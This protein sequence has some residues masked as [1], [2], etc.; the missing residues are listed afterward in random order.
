MFIKTQTFFKL[1]PMVRLGNRT[2]RGCENRTYRGC[3]NRTY[4]G[5]ESRIQEL[6]NSHL[7]H[8]AHVNSP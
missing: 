7:G 1:M 5:C 2:Y 8:R 4:R 6:K 3:E